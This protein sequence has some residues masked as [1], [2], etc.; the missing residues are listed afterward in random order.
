MIPFKVYYRFVTMKFDYSTLIIV[1]I[2][3]L[4][5][6]VIYVIVTPIDGVINVYK[7]E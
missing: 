6:N 2:I 4:K 1:N 5:I 7:I 3:F